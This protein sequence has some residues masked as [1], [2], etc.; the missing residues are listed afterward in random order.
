MRVLNPPE[1]VK[2]TICRAVQMLLL[3]VINVLYN[4]LKVI[5]KYLNVSTYTLHECMS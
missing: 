2:Q 3:F 1:I 5:G 4:K